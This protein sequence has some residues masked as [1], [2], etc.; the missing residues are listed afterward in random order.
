MSEIVQ[1]YLETT[2]GDHIRSMPD[3]ELSI[4]LASIADCVACPANPGDGDEC[5]AFTCD[6][7]WLDWLKQECKE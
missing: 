3:K 2:N 7:A 5:A 6:D 1:K 4:L